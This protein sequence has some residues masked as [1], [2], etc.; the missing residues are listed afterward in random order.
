MA[1]DAAKTPTDVDAIAEGEVLD[2]DAEDVVYVDSLTATFSA[3]ASAEADDIHASG[4][5]IGSSHSNSLTATASAIGL[6]NV[7]GDAQITVSAVPILRTAGGA[8]F[9]Q[10]YA[11]AV[12]VGGDMEI[13]QAAAP[14]I[15]GKQLDATQVGAAVV[16]TGD[17][18]IKRSTI[19]LLL[20][21][22]ANVSEDSRVLL[23]T[24]A[25]LIIACAL[26]GGFAFVAIALIMSAQRVAE[27]R[28]EISF[29]KISKLM[30]EF[31]GLSLQS[32]PWKRA[33]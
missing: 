10:A 27:W 28:P 23:S 24:K 31:K 12:I 8:T 5:A 18:D 3:I 7:D 30:E 21:R 14:V 29:P 33:A 20:S 22:S 9:S 26:F 17:A 25:A 6:A 13:H 2:T 16:I 1:K 32:P 15:I 4:S 11:S 19:G